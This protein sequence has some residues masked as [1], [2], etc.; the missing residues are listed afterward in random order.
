MKQIYKLAQRAFEKR[1]EAA[2]GSLDKVYHMGHTDGYLDGFREAREMAAKACER[3][4]K[5]APQVSE[6]D[7]VKNA[8]ALRKIGEREETPCGAV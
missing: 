8:A 6:T 4:M 7:W 5:Y 2:H 3:V 1:S